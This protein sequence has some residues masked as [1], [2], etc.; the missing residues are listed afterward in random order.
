MSLCTEEILKVYS[1]RWDIEVGY[2]YLKDRLGMGHYQMRKLK[3]IKKY[4]ALVFAAYGLLE[5]MRIAANEKSIGK[6][7]KMFSIMKKR[8]YVDRIIDLNRRGVSKRKIYE[9]LKLVA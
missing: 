9:Q 2:F 4:C 1:Y 6:S 7:R 5:A 3:V 8:S